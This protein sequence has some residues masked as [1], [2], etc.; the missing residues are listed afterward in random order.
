V[1]KNAVALFGYNGAKLNEGKAI[2]SEAGTLYEAQQREFGEVSGAQDQFRKL[3][4]QSNEAYI[5]ML[6]IARVAFKNS[7]QAATTLELNGERASN[8][9]G[10]LKQTRN[11]YRALLANA[12]W[13]AVMNSYGQ[14]GEKITGALQTVDAVNLSAEQVK[15]AMGDARNA[16]YL[17]DLKFE[18]LLEWLKDY[19]NIT[20]IAL[21][22]SPQLLEKLG[23]VVKS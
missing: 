15:K 2:L 19:D 5:S 4:E 8:F 12:E 16:T 17:R 1:I 21:A 18:E 9:G 22:G 10:W 3:R 20:R 14:T 13:R 23:I 11:F 6:V 7:V